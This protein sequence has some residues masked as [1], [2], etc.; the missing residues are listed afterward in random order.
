MSIAGF[1]A[2]RIELKIAGEFARINQQKA[3]RAW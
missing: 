1:G 2:R 3:D